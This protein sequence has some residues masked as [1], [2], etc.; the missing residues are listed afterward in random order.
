[1]PITDSLDLA[2]EGSN[3]SRVHQALIGEEEITFMAQ[4]ESWEYRFDLGDLALEGKQ[5]AVHDLN[6]WGQQ[7]WEV[8]ALLP[9]EMAECVVLLKK[10]VRLNSQMT[11]SSFIRKR[12]AKEWL[13]AVAGAIAGLASAV[14]SRDPVVFFFPYAAFQLVRS[15]IWAI[16]TLRKPESN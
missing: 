4:P 5:D 8:V 9:I 3:G 7:G 16:K 6:K 13:Y 15:V 10:K 2:D 12:I 11:P 14:A 1:M